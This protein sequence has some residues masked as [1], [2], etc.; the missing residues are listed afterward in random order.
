[1][2][3]FSYDLFSLALKSM[4]VH[5]EIDEIVLSYV[6]SI[7]QDLTSGSYMDEEAFDVD[8]FCET[9]VAYMP[10]TETIAPEEITEW[11]FT[12][13]QQ[14][15]DKAASANKFQLNLK[16]VI[17]ET[18]NKGRKISESSLPSD[19]L[20]VKSDKN[21][22]VGRSSESS[23]YSNSDVDVSINVLSFILL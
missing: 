12:L 23:D 20:D 5:R 9:L 2:A 7:M 14:E 10:N 21:G 13:A 1:M 3:P 22:R 16:S 15:R 11:I 17:E 19:D 6:V 4:F 8:A 18:A